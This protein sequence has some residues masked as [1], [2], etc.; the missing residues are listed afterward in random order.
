MLVIDAADVSFDREGLFFKDI[1]FRFC[2]LPEI[3]PE[4]EFLLG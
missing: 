4:R 1:S 3:I 2:D